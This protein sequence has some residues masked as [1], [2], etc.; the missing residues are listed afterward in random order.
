MP[1]A[2]FPLPQWHLY[3]H[4]RDTWEPLKRHLLNGWKQSP[5]DI[6]FCC[7]M[8]HLQL[9]L[10]TGGALQLR[11]K[12]NSCWVLFSPPLYCKC[13]NHKQMVPDYSIEVKWFCILNKVNI[14]SYWLHS[15]LSVYQAAAAT[16]TEG[17]SL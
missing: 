12:M 14:I 5:A 4:P 7:H 17:C 13:L 2:F 6:S 8:R 1:A 15:A 3:A 16:M 10:N 11:A 9:G